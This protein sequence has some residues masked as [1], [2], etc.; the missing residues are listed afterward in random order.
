MTVPAPNEREGKSFRMYIKA[1]LFH[2]SGELSW[3]SQTLETQHDPQSGADALW[4][5]QFEWYYEE[6]DLSF[7]RFVARLYSL[8]MCKSDSLLLKTHD[9][10][11]RGGQR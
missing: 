7:I 4:K 1:Q 8:D 11:R 3:R 6:D 5:E 9:L 10:P 2:S